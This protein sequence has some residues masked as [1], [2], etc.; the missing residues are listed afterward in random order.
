MFSLPLCP[1]TPL[2]VLSPALAPA[3]G[4]TLQSPR[5]GAPGPKTLA[6]VAGR[7]S[8]GGAAIEL[9]VD[10]RSLERLHR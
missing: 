4:S 5:S 9:S 6:S 3:S 8:T 1:K 2:P 10:G 7:P